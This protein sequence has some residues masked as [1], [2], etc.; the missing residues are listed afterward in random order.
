M[1]SLISRHSEVNQ[2]TQTSSSNY[3]QNY[4]FTAAKVRTMLSNIQ[5]YQI[6]K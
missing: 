3:T 6:I 4:C 1:Y 5:L 2:F